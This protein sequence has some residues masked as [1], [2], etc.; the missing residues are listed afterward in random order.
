MTVSKTRSGRYFASFQVEV[1]IAAPAFEGVVNGLDLGLTTYA[2]LSD[3][4]KFEK[5]AHLY[6]A[7]RRLRRGHRRLSRRTRGSQGYKKQRLKV[8]RMHEKVA[9]QRADFQ[10]KLSRRLV[11]EHRLLAIEDLHVKGMVKNRRLAKRIS[12]AAWSQFVGMPGYKGDWYG[13]ELAVASRWYPSSKT[14]SVCESKMAKMPLAVRVWVCP[15]CG[16]THDRDINAAR[17]LLKQTTVGTTER[18]YEK[19]SDAGRVHIRP[20]IEQ[21]GTQKPEAQH[22]DAG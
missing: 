5:P 3:G 6:R 10:H 18:C 7:E 4:S 1:E 8:A 13:C 22:L 21:A 20:A 15:D 14:C 2:V 19:R 17:N 16:T 9:N 12:D 11:E